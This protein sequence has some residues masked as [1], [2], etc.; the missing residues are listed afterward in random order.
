MTDD[1]ITKEGAELSFPNGGRLVVD[2]VTN[3]Q[4]Y[5]R[6]WYPNDEDARWRWMRPALFVE[7]V[8]K[9]LHA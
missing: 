3:H 4:V 1:E 8:R 9:A 6:L 2:R 7:A 5:Y